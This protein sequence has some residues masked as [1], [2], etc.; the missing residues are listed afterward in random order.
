MVVRSD[1]RDLS[2]VSKQELQEYVLDAFNN[3]VPTGAQG[4]RPRSQDQGQRVAFMAIFREA[5]ADQSSHFHVAIKLAGSNARVF[6]GSCCVY[7]R[8]LLLSYSFE[9]TLQYVR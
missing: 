1:L 7:P 3:T 6:Q 5:H 2:G 8:L 9:H 4:G